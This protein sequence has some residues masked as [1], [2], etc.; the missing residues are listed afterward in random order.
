MGFLDKVVKTVGRYEEG[1]NYKLGQSLNSTAVTNLFGNGGDA[2]NVVE[3]YN[4][5]AWKA[6]NI[7]ASML[8][9]EDLFVERLVGKEW[10]IDQS[11]PFN[12]VLEGQEGGNDL[13]ELLY[14]HSI[15]MDMYGESF[16]YFSKG[17]TSNKPFGIYLLD[18]SAMT[19]MVSGSRVTGYVYQKDGD[20]L[21]LELDEV[22]HR[23]IP[24]SRTPFRG[25]GPMQ[26]AGWF[27]K[28][29][30]YL[31]TYMNN[32][33]DNNAIPAGVVVAEGGVDDNDWKLFKEQWTAKYSGVANAGKTGFLRGKDIDFLK[34]G[35]SLGDV[36]FDKLKN[37]SRDDVMVMFGIS[38]PMMAIFDDINRASATV[39]RQ[40]FAITFTKPE[41]MSLKRKLT[42]KV[43]KWYG[44]QFRV[45]STNPVPEDEDSKLAMYEKG[46]GIWVTPNEA[47]AAYGLPPI[48]GGDQLMPGEVVAAKSIGTVR[49]KSNTI[50]KNNKAEFSYEMKESYRSQVEDLQI[51]YEEKLTGIVRDV[52]VEQK[53]RVLDQIAPKKSLVDTN[54]DIDKEAITL[55]EALLPVFMELAREQGI[56][57]IQFAVND[58]AKFELTPAME[59][60]IAE[61]L[62]K[63]TRSFTEETQSKL[64]DAVI[65]GINDGENMTELAKRITDI[66]V[67]VIPPK[68]GGYDKAWRSERFAR[69]EVIKASNEVAE[70]AYRQSGVVSKKEWFA[71]PGHC[72]YCAT[73][74][75]SIISLG[76]SFVPQGSR[77]EGEEGGS[78]QNNYENVSHPPL[79]PQC[80]CTLVPVIEN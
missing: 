32:F 76:L 3:E 65:A 63:T 15:S 16:W 67:E 8:S 18:P 66:Y 40:L 9:A 19:V 72:Q 73:L 45:E 34:T 14:A 37:S 41:L 52:L 56:M 5:F 51:K 33:M 29:S 17:E 64:A 39:A 4:G 20:R 42:K 27:I 26:A 75:G 1:A 58:L 79:H 6:I 30:R 60:Y 12:E 48:P 80:R 50:K 78:R 69:T 38:K 44:A 22:M 24:S 35:L 77:I 31:Y 49:I 62:L 47:R 21:V 36:D 55:Q 57:S 25:H 70:A 28:S 59:K 53:E 11:H 43:S 71:N 74:N 13:S 61:S 10:Q 2:I 23:Y 54:I 68:K 7:R 46:T